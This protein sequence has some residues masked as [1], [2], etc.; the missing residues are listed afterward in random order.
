[1]TARIWVFAAAFVC[2]KSAAYGQGIEV[3]TGLAACRSIADSL[4]R[5][6]C[7]DSLADGRPNP[8]SAPALPGPTNEPGIPSG[9]KVEVDVSPLDRSP[10][11][12]ATIFSTADS[13]TDTALLGLRCIENRTSLAVITPRGHF[14][15]TDNDRLSV[16]FRVGDKEP[17]TAVWGTSMENSNAAFGPSGTAAILFI[18]DL[19]NAE[20]FVIRVSPT[21]A[22]AHTYIFNLAGIEDAIDALALA[23]S[24]PIPP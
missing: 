24:W 10:R 3:D 9:W 19:A 18:R 6:T 5:L 20:D 4:A 15:F 1:M 2:F 22:A 12:I 13:I 16:S 23:C 14:L 7:Y 17:Q 11:V 8:S 21:R